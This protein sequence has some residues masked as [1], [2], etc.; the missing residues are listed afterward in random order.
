[1]L[2]INAAYRHLVTRK[3]MLCLN[4]DFADKIPTNMVGSGQYDLN[5]RQIMLYSNKSIWYDANDDD[6]VCEVYAENLAVSTQLDD[7]GRI[8]ETETWKD[9]EKMYIRGTRTDAQNR[10]NLKNPGEPSSYFFKP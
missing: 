7:C 10:K 6:G 4:M 3:E 9:Q 1:M 2:T 5:G 8:V